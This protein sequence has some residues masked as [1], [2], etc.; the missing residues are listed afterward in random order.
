MNVN[1]YEYLNVYSVSIGWNGT[2][3]DENVIFLNQK[4]LKEMLQLNLNPP[5]TNIRHQSLFAFF[6]LL[7]C[8]GLGISPLLTR[9]LVILGCMSTAFFPPPEFPSAVFSCSLSM[10]TDCLTVARAQGV[11]FSYKMTVSQVQVHRNHNFVHVHTQHL[12]SGFPALLIAHINIHSCLNMRT[13]S[14]CL[15]RCLECD[16]Y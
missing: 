15:S 2:C 5:P 3:V 8:L 1:E 4:C 10:I 7:L 13:R 6:V 12:F 16:T 11:K 9:T 14:H